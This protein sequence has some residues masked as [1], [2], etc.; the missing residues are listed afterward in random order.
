MTTNTTKLVKELRMAADHLASLQ[1]FADLAQGS[2][3]MLKKV[4]ECDQAKISTLETQ[5]T[6]LVD[7]VKKLINCPRILDFY[8]M[9]PDFGSET[10][11]AVSNAEEV[12]RNI[13]GDA[14]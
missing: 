4:H 3:D 14:S 7:A 1:L 2:I 11:S 12:L 9:D 10:H 13:K 6:E 8:S 5:N